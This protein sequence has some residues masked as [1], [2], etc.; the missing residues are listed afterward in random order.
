MSTLRATSY[1]RK[2][3]N[4][5]R[6][7]QKSFAL[8]ILATF[9][10]VETKWRN[11]G[12]SDRAAISNAKIVGVQKLLALARERVVNHKEVTKQKFKMQRFRRGTHAGDLWVTHT[13]LSRCLLSNASVALLHSVHAS[14]L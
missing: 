11:A 3:P 6:I 10:S 2:K 13:L 12:V 8:F 9:F 5:F 4:F 1:S 14:R 7:L